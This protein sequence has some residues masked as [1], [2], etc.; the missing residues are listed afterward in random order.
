MI[1]TLPNRELVLLGGGHTHLHLLRMWKMRPLPGVRLTC[2]SNRWQAA[3]SGMVPGTLAGQYPVEQ[4]QVDLVRRCQAVGARLLLAEC[5]GLDLRNQQLHFADR[6]PLPYDRLSI[7]IGSRPAAV[8]GLEHALSIKPMQTFLPRLRARVQAALEKRR[9]VD[10]GRSPEAG[11]PLRAVVAGGGAGGVEIAFCLPAFI[12]QHFPAA[13]LELTLVDRG[14]Q[15]LSGASP[16]AVRRAERVLE[17]RGHRRLMHCEVRQLTSE[18]VVVE[19]PQEGSQHL[20]AD[21]VIWAVGAV[22]P[23]LFAS[24]ELPKDDAGFLLV[25]ESL[26]SLGSSSIFVVGDS[27]TCP[28]RPTPKAGVY[29]VR[30]GPVLW[31][32]LQRSLH[33]EPL[34]KWKPQRNFLSLLNTGDG[35]AVLDYRGWSAEGR[36]CWWLK[37]RI[38]RRFM[39]KHQDYSLDAMAA[40]R[41]AEQRAEREAPMRCAGC[42]GKLASTTLRRVLARLDNP[43][44]PRIKLG[45]EQAEDVAEIDWTGGASVVATTDFFAAFLDDPFV[46]GRVAALNALSDLFA[47]GTV[48]TAALAH[49]IVPPG[50]AAQQEQLLFEWLAGSL[51]EFRPLGVPIVGGHS[52]E[53]EQGVF[54]FTLLGERLGRR[55]ERPTER[56]AKSTGSPMPLKAGLAA[57]DHLVLSK[58]L[59]SGVLLAAHRQAKCR[60]PDLQSLL[61]SMLASNQAAAAVAIEAGLAA[62]TDVTG[63]GLLGHLLE[64]LDSS[65]DSAPSPLTAELDLT[66]LPLLPGAE[67]ALRAGIES[68]LAE[69][70]RAAAA[71]MLPDEVP[72]EWAGRYRAMFD[73][74]T[75]GGLLMGVAEAQ[76][77]SVLGGLRQAGLSPAVI[78]RVEASGEPSG[79]PSRRIRW[80]ASAKR[81]AAGTRRN[82][83][84]IDTG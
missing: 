49:A 6:P 63:F 48:P 71:G 45:L 81:D 27:G 8:S 2:I 35:R 60:G 57:G 19:H 72:A 41:G 39:A 83:A 43:S 79:A 84:G 23:E 53:G 47:K 25:D 76:L 66:A 20:A 22:G 18:S 40:V 67:A 73:P 30:Q 32:N 68:T 5:V 62:V 1:Q 74:Q 15:L 44:S 21:V 36:W 46:V 38:D 34:R 82:A 17:E 58:P 31:E 7:G 14:A 13:T 61:A 9:P 12:A 50:P 80:A 16:S 42:G 28:S 11:R 70:N 33:G 56:G 29:A 52:I 24:F 3:Y 54:G 26:R 77:S 78:G 4:M 64:M 75:S 51:A 10:A 55:G 37:D 69:A 59:G 65:R